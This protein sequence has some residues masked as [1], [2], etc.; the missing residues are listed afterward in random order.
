MK[1][2]DDNC[3]ADLYANSYFRGY[4]NTTE[5]FDTIE[6]TWA[7]VCFY[8]SNINDSTVFW[9]FYIFLR[10]MHSMN[11]RIFESPIIA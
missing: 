6:R 9:I 11:F 7:K 5:R 8:P 3:I 1:N 10:H 4:N 2:C